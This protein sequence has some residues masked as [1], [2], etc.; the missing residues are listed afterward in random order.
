[1]IR[2]RQFAAERFG[3]VRRPI[4]V[5]QHL[6]REQ[7]H[8]GLTIANDVRRS[9]APSRVYSRSW[10][11]LGLIR[12]FVVPEFRNYLLFYQIKGNDLILLRVKFGGMD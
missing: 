2:R 6:P 11:W 12:S 1:L 5:H 4:R 3:G 10:W 8:V 9:F 7:H